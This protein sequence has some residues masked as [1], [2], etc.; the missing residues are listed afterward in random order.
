MSCG[1]ATPAPPIGSAMFAS[2]FG[3]LGPF[4][5]RPHIAVACSGGAD[6]MAL[7]L[8]LQNWSAAVG[9]SLTALTVDHRLRPESAAEAARVATW[10]RDKGIAHEVLVRPDTPLGGNLQA[11]ARRI[12]YALMSEWC[13]RHGVLHLA[14][15]HHLEDQAET[16]L[17]R[18]G[19]GSGVDGLA[20][21]APV[22]ETPAVRLLRP[23]LG[24]PRARLAAT[25]RAVGQGHV[26]DPS[27]ENAGFGRVRLRRAEGVLAR[28]GLTAA[29]LAAT[30]GRLGRA[31]AALD[32]AVTEL[33]AHSVSL[34]GEGY[35][36]VDIADFGSAPEEVALRALARV[37]TT[38]S[39]SV[40]P[41]RYERLE[42]LYR[43]LC[44]PG[45]GRGPGRTLGGCRILPQ[46]GKVIVCR[47][48]AAADEAAPAAGRFIWDGRFRVAIDGDI[49]CT[50][51]RLGRQGWSDL[52]A[53]RPD[54]RTPDVPAAVR[55]SLPS[56]WYLDVMVAVPHLSYVRKGNEER[57]ASIR[58]I[59][60]SPQR[61]LTGSRFV[62]GQSGREGLTVDAA[63]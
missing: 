25:L 51:R 40:Y 54:M 10:M 48:P 1:V 44:G 62:S 18:L 55:P 5:A 46:A 49:G 15:A 38:V 43:D 58:E 53:D 2:L 7:T 20:A 9:G 42:R 32:S 52:V 60:F 41:P 11:A 30:A 26:A 27:N 23:L 35:A 57:F 19:R 22:L 3:A 14:L 12:R 29:R 56:F 13:E 6:S 63:L 59:A 33:L 47:E 61:P 21:M 31:R 24:V 4:E 8:L 37:L 17:L 28:E 39:G 36:T 16:L 34:H 45:E 50:L